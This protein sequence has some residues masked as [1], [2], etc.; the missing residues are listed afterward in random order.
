MRILTTALGLTLVAGSVSAM[1]DKQGHP[2]G[3]FV[4]K[5]ASEPVGNITFLQH[6]A[7]ARI[8]DSS[9]PPAWRMRMY[10]HG[11]SAPIT[12]R[13]GMVV[14]SACQPRNCAERNWAVAV[15]KDGTKGAVCVFDRND[16]AANGW[17][18]DGEKLILVTAA[19][20]NRREPAIAGKVIIYVT[21][22]DPWAGY[23]QG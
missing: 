11:V 19:C 22:I 9:A 10:D 3:S 21:G 5:Y 23:P 2:I 18:A 20:P 8:V 12:E 17:Y 16:P 1:N 15:A 4:G 13:E 14:H 6:P 7:V